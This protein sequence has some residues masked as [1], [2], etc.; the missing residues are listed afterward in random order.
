MYSHA[1]KN[2]EH[3][4]TTLSFTLHLEGQRT[5]ASR[6]EVKRLGRQKP[7]A[8]L[9]NDFADKQAATNTMTA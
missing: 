8:A 3:G 5:G 1:S 9:K 7:K 4:D 2:T 6:E